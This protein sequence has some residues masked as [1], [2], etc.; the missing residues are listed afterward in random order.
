MWIE[1]KINVK[2]IFVNLFY[3]VCEIIFVLVMGI[4]GG[5]D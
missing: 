2:Y 4:V 5:G 3:L 1:I